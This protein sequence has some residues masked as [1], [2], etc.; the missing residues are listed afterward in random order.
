ML[1]YTNALYYSF[2]LYL[3]IFLLEG[4]VRTWLK[5]LRLSALSRTLTH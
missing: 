3:Y 2:S 1:L 4:Y 5:S